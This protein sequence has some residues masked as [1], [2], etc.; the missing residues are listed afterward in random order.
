[1]ARVC[2]DIQYSK[3]VVTNDQEAIN[4]PD[5][6]TKACA[7]RWKVEQYQRDVKQNTGK[8]TTKAYY[9][10]YSCMGRT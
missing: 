7:A 1:M 6:A 4:T 8:G 10:G 2:S 3:T 5:D 9:N